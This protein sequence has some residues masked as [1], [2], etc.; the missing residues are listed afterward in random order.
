MMAKVRDWLSR[1]VPGTRAA[2]V[3]RE[4]DR[5]AASHN[6]RRFA[7]GDRPVI[8]WIKG[9]GFDDPVTRSAIGQATRLF[10]ARVDYCL[11]TNGIDAARARSMLDWA[12]QPVEWWPL[13]RDDNP[14]LAKILEAVDCTP[15]HYGYWWKWFPE[16]ARAGAPEW[17]LDGDMVITG[18]PPW[19][20]AWTQGRD[21]CRMTQDDRWPIE[22]MYGSYAD[23][24]D[25]RQ[26]LYSGLISL[27]P[28]LRYMDKIEAVL[29]AKP[30]ASGHDGRRD[31]C[32]QGVVAAAFQ[33]VGA[34]PIP[35]YEF[36]F[37]RAF[38]H[39]LD[40]GLQG[41]RGV[42]WGYHFGNSFRRDN[43]HFDRLI[44]EGVIFSRN[45]TPSTIERFT[46]LGGFGQW[47]VPGWTIPDG[48]AQIIL[49]H[50][51]HFAGR[52][53]LELGTSRGRLTSML[54][55]VGCC[56]TTV[57]RHDRGATQNLEGLNVTVII[58]DAFEFL[59]TVSDTF[60]LIVVDLHGNSVKNWQ[61]LAPLL[62]RCLSRPGM[63]LL[64]NAVLW[65]IP[66]WRTESGVDWFLKTLR[67]PWQFK[68]YADTL[69][70][71]AVVT[72]G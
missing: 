63:L 23:R 43:P 48:C 49:Q 18:I 42:G 12:T 65:K 53:V 67:R 56:V 27:P 20:D 13:T 3:T 62:K 60:D 54:A 69:P 34:A 71:V 6:G 5:I 61:R 2:H 46:W 41:D 25:E 10:G 8:R 33:E 40:Y 72:N 4:D 31:L 59:A 9:D 29:A 24:V 58:G 44:S 17:I 39:I 11:C 14:Y 35:L 66:E 15:E 70:G 30:L 57:D 51:R 28:G 1:L 16:R 7:H 19:F 55:A 32:E 52:R 36:P 47:G 68:V 22:E 45:D 37:G 38:E 50:A 26:R 21:I 64:D